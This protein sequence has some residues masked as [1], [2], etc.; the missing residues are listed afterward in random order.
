[1]QP[2]IASGGKELSNPLQVEI[3]KLVTA[4]ETEAQTK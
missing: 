3:V 2:D 4:V 1:M